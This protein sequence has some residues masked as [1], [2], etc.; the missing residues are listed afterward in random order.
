MCI[1]LEYLKTK[2]K[3][4][5]GYGV[6][7]SYSQFGED[8]I[9]QSFIKE[10]IGTYIDVGT[11][12]PVLY[13]NTYALY[14]K[15]WR[16]L[17]IDPNSSL[18]PLYGLLRPRDTFIAAGVGAENTGQYHM[19]SDGAY[20][21]FNTENVGAYK[22]I[23]RLKYFGSVE[24]AIIPLSKIVHNHGVKEIGFLN[25][26]VEGNDLQV[27]QSYDWSIRPKIIA[28]ESS[29]FNPDAPQENEIYRLLRSK[30]YRL[31]G[32]SSV[33]LLWVDNNQ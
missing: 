15:G 18:E 21:T 1:L 26:D 27:L 2:A 9:L 11:Y 23:S 4:C 12:H 28:I 29:D 3:L 17:V 20:N 14:K 16:G 7:K 10:T 8:I 19:F 31:A 33:S 25:I 6:H 5:L 22:R 13:S 30:K 32:L 24:R